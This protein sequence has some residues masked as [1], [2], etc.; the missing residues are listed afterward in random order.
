MHL[1]VKDSQSRRQSVMQ[2][3]LYSKSPGGT[4]EAVDGIPCR[5]SVG[6]EA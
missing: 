2:K 3:L 6:M 4:G 1:P 5:L